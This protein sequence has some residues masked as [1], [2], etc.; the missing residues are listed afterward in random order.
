MPSVYT[1]ESISH[2]PSDTYQTEIKHESSFSLD[3]G[4]SCHDKLISVHCCIGFCAP[5]AGLL[6][7]ILRNKYF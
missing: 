1:G 2:Q 5:G 6:E 7:Q 4:I 3:L